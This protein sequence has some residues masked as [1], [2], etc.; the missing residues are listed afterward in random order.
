MDLNSLLR[1]NYDDI[2]EAA[3]EIPAAVEWLNQTLQY[4]L[5]VKVTDQAELSR[6][7]ADVYRKLRDG[8]YEEQYADKMTEAALERAVAL[9]DNIRQLYSNCAESEALVERL[10]NTIKVLLTRLDILRTVESTRRH[11]DKVSGD[12][13]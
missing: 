8:G 2:G 5:S 1:R 11:V 12:I 7:K 9:D 6:T 4:Y 10:R 13:R 3:V